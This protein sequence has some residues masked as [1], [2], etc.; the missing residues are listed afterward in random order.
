MGR[1]RTERPLWR[2]VRQSRAGRQICAVR[3]RQP[4]RNHRRAL[5]Q[6]RARAGRDIPPR[7]AYGV[8]MSIAPNSASWLTGTIADLPTP[9]SV[10]GAVD[11][12]AF[13]NLCER[14]IAAG[15]S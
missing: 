10:D 9:F 14:Q 4:P 13:A 11:L 5:A 6:D 15:A 7:A 1:A 2:S 8:A 12:I 3:E